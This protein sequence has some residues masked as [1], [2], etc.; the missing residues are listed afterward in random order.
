ML[1]VDL[2]GVV[3]VH[4]LEL[5]RVLLF[6][7]GHNHAH[8]GGDLSEDDSRLSLQSLRDGDLT[9]MLRELILQPEAEG[10]HIL[11]WEGVDSG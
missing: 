7:H 10:R 2:Q 9:H 5:P 3:L 8:G 1:R 11:L 4:L 6:H